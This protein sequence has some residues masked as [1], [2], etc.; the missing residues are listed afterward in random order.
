MIF[1]FGTRFFGR[2]DE[3]PGL[4]HVA[5][6]FGHLWYIPLV[7]VGSWLVLR[8]SGNAI[9]GIKIPLSGK[10]ILVAWARAGLI[11]LALFLAVGAAVEASDRRPNPGAAAVMGVLAGVA[12]IGA[13]FAWRLGFLK[14]ARYERAVS[15]AKSA[16]LPEE[17]AV[18]IDMKFR[19]LSLEEGQQLLKELKEARQASPGAAPPAAPVGV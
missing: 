7:P 13:V 8:K 16:K 9:R 4:F 10:S 18:L 6:K 17:V 2:V 14:N 15:L 19:K 1:I 5:T 11:A 12:G 3:V